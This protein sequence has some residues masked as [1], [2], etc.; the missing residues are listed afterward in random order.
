M[1]DHLKQII[2]LA[3]PRAPTWPRPTW[4]L[5]LPEPQVRV[6][7]ANDLGLSSADPEGDMLDSLSKKHSDPNL[8][9]ACNAV[10][11]QLATRLRE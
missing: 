5:H 3:L 1:G 10:L 2:A 4:R 6:N 11:D 9:K 8:V 7:R